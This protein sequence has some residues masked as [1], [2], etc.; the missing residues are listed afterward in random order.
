MK[1]SKEH[2]GEG[3]GWSEAH[4]CGSWPA[5]GVTEGALRYRLKKLDEGR[6]ADQPT[7]LNGYAEAVEAIQL[8]LED[9]RLTGRPRAR[10][11]LP[12]QR[13][14]RHARGCAALACQSAS[15][16]GDT[17]AVPVRRSD[18]SAPAGGFG[19]LAPR[20]RTPPERGPPGESKGGRSAPLAS[21]NVTHWVGGTPKT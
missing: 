1:L 17:R 19:G 9:G 12:Q 3:D 10:H 18:I 6:R 16:A 11:G 13:R 20:P 15:S 5:A 2:G 4:R 14:Q 7:A 8:A 21:P